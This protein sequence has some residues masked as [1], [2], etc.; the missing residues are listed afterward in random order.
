M[1]HS[2]IYYSGRKNIRSIIKNRYRLNTIVL[3]ELIKT[4]NEQ[5]TLLKT[6]NSNTIGWILGHIIL[7][8]GSVLKLLQMDYDKMNSEENYKRGSE[9]NDMIN[10]ESQNAMDVFERRGKQ[11]VN[12]VKEV[13]EKI[14]DIEIKYNMPGGGN[15][16]K[17]AIL[18]SSWH[19]T[20]HIG[21]IDLILAANGRGGIK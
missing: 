18:F 21:Q 16:V 10:I 19:E 7:S 2:P 11:I 20:F 1:L 12:A 5:D 14:L 17:D 15:T 13:D 3:K 4:L 9:K 6:G 8:R